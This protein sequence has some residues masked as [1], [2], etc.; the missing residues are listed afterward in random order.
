V[1]SNCDSRAEHTAS[2]EVKLLSSSGAN[3]RSNISGTGF[4]GTNI[5]ET[6]IMSDFERGE[7]KYMTTRKENLV[8]RKTVKAF[9]EQQKKHLRTR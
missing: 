3:H 1:I 6:W 7:T 9:F 8:V 4:P 2:V 5:N